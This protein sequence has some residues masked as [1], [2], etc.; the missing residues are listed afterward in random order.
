MLKAHPS[1][2]EMK[3]YTAE[4]FCADMDAILD[5]ITKEDTAYIIDT[6]KGQ[7]VIK[8]VV[9]AWQGLVIWIQCNHFP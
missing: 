3:H 1:T 4:E 8:I 2:S 6:D 7:Y 9:S 5:S